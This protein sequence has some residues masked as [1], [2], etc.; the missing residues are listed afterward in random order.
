MAI[1]AK[2]K[3]PKK[4]APQTAPGR[5]SLHMTTPR[6]PLAQIQ[7]NM[8]L[9]P[10]R[11]SHKFLTALWKIMNNFFCHLFFPEFFLKKI[12]G[13]MLRSAQGLWLL[14]KQGASRKQLKLA[15]RPGPESVWRGIGSLVLAQPKQQARAKKTSR[16]EKTTSES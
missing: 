13:R 3:G 8:K 6:P 1:S 5:L 14:L 12:G 9:C 4:N 16:K 15:P 11:L 7:I 10:G 2:A